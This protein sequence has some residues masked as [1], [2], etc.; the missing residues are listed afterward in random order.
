[1]TPED[2][3]H[4]TRFGYRDNGCRCNRCKKAIA[5]EHNIYWM[6]R[7]A[8]GGQPLTVDKLGAVRRLQALMAIGWPRRE[9]AAQ[10]GYQGD[11]F[12]LILN[13][14]RTRLTL[15]TNDRIAELFDRLSMTPGPSSPGRVR[16]AKK[17]WPPPLAWL[18]ID[19]P[20]EQPDT[21]WKPVGNRKAAE[22]LAE[23]E[24]LTGCGVSD[25]HAAQ[26]LGV[27]VAAIEKAIERERAA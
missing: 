14:R 2:P 9:L 22:L 8:N 5:L 15:S 23:F 20:D 26:Q 7:G 4:G 3:R 18:N 21:G 17:G 16:A 12:A 13:G 24:H 25:F 6:R 1:M 10:A 11:A 19:D 27:T